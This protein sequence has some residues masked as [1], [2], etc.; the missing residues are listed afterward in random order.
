MT[1]VTHCPWSDIGRRHPH[2]H[3]GIHDISP[4]RA[5]WV[6]DAQVVFIDRQLTRAEGRSALAHEIAHIDL[7]HEPRG[8]AWF[9]TRQ[10]R[11]ADQLA[12]RRLIPIEA[13][14]DIF[15]WTRDDEAAAESLAVDVHTVRV[16]LAHLHPSERHHIEARIA[17]IEHVA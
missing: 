12:A 15:T 7:A 8:L 16:R 1:H 10:E 14:A 2:V 6:R 4:A 17:L 3:V 11:E 5:A 9:D 13:L